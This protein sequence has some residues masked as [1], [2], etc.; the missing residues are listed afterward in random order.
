VRPP[1]LQ[2]AYTLGNIAEGNPWQANTYYP[3]GA[4]VAVGVW[5]SDTMNTRM[6]WVA[7]TAGISGSSK[8]LFLSYLPGSGA[9]VAD[10]NVI[11]K[12]QHAPTPEDVANSI[13]TNDG[14]SVAKISMADLNFRVDSVNGTNSASEPYSMPFTMLQGSKNEITIELWADNKG[15]RIHVIRVNDVLAL[16]FNDRAGTT[17]YNIIPK[18]WELSPASDPRGT[19]I[20]V[21]EATADFFSS[22]NYGQTLSEKPS[23]GI[24]AK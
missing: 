16:G 18:D 14:F 20:R 6:V 9:T 7:T 2:I 8:P 13:L 22:G 23:Y 21:W 11:W 24:W 17:K 1:D 12:A 15:N 5:T 3:V 10:N 19:G 4:K